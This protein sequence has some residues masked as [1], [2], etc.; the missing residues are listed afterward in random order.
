MA[1]HLSQLSQKNTSTNCLV[2]CASGLALA[3]SF[4]RLNLDLLAWVA[5]V[6]LLYV[7]DDKTDLRVFLYAWLQGSVFG[8]VSFSWLIHFMRDFAGFGF[9]AAGLFLLSLAAFVALFGAAAL[10]VGFRVSRTFGIP[11]FFSIPPAWVA[12]EWLRAHWP[13]GGLP[14]NLLG[15]ATQG[16]I[17][18]IQVA[19]LTG[20]YGVSVL[21]MFVN[22]ALY[23]AFRPGR[24]VRRRRWILL[25]T[26]ASVS[27][28]L[29]FGMLRIHGLKLSKTTGALQIA[30]VQGDIPQHY[31]WNPAYLGPSFQV[32]ADA[33]ME[34]S[35]SHPRPQLIIWPESAATFIFE[36]DD[37][38][39][40]GM[41]SQR[42]YRTRLLE[43]AHKIETP[44]L[45][46]APAL[47]FDRKVTLRNRAYLI[48]GD[49]QVVDYYDKLRLVPGGEYIPLHFL[50][51]RFMHR[52]VE[53]P[54]NMDCSPGD[55]RTIFNVD[56]TN[57]S[58]LI[59]Y[60]SMFP[61]LSRAAVRGGA[62]VLVSMTNDAAF[63]DTAA[64]Y[65]LLGMAVF[66]AVE[67]GVP[68]VRVGNSGI[69]AVISSTGRVADATAPFS[70]ATEVETVP[71]RQYRT[72]YNSVG[73]L[74]AKTV[75]RVVHHR[76]CGKPFARPFHR[77]LAT[78][79]SGL[80]ML[81]RTLS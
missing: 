55:R 4:P 63:G 60:E 27:G 80:A 32:Y 79:R 30:L 3:A 77:R 12:T 29:L 38:Y 67:N 41:E 14:L 16:R 66:R 40:A 8:V 19:A 53:T 62:S 78:R 7:L 52:L 34:A 45:F 68:L 13:L 74:F 61:D 9:I 70:R 42:A 33:S 46:G 69:S 24:S 35:S 26:S 25:G 65:Q 47:D 54:G 71:W 58:V 20:V 10:V 17:A 6:P 44:I 37:F 21:I 49:G 28:V 73:D 51:G 64:P 1:Y 48:E 23:E 5:F 72:S 2:A 15:V 36:A 76:A 43:L 56:G 81:V 39:P 57:L 59:Y 18:V 75:H 22:C 50:A 11:L 31:K